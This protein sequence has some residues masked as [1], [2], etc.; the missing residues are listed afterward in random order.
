M[1]AEAKSKPGDGPIEKNQTA[2]ATEFTDRQEGET[3]ACT[4]CGGNCGL[5][6][7]QTVPWKKGK[8]VQ[9]GASSSKQVYLFDENHQAVTE[10][11]TAAFMLNPTMSDYEIEK[12]KHYSQQGIRVPHFEIGR[13]HV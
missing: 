2:A 5:K 6:C 11:A 1:S 7:K 10:R 4:Q 3:V 13:A 8:L 12:Y 9:W